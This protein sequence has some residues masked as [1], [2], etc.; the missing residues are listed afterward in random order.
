MLFCYQISFTIY[1]IILIVYFLTP[2]N[3]HS[4]IRSELILLLLILGLKV[5]LLL[6]L[7]H[8][9]HWDSCAKL[10]LLLALHW[11]HTTL[12]VGSSHHWLL[13]LE[14]SLELALIH[15]HLRI[16]SCEKLAL[17]L[18]GRVCSELVSKSWLRLE[19]TTH[20]LLW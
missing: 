11:I 10:L 4:L 17:V 19:T 5:L 12:G 16:H 7:T 18:R 3:H 8:L 20:L 2:I 9:V 15:I 13:L 6:L 14:V 1:I